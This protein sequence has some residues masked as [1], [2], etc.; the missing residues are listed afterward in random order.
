MGLARELRVGA[1]HL[2]TTVNV[3]GTNGYMEQQYLAQGQF[4]KLADGYAMGIT[5][6]VILTRWHAFEPEAAHIHAR[7]LDRGKHEI[8]VMI[9]YEHAGWPRE[10]AMEVLGVAAW[11]WI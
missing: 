8:V 6:L 7:C 11:R 9:A 10:V 2:T 1:G 5:L 3:S 4:D